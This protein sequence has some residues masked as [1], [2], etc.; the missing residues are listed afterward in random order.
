MNETILKNPLSSETI[1]VNDLEKYLKDANNILIYLDDDTIPY[2]MKR[3]YFI[4]LLSEDFVFECN[5]KNKIDVSIKYYDLSKLFLNVEGNHEIIVK[6]SD[7]IDIISDSGT[8]YFK[9]KSVVDKTTKKGIKKLTYTNIDLQKFVYNEGHDYT[10]TSDGIPP[11]WKA[12]AL[13]CGNGYTSINTYLVRLTDMPNVRRMKY[14]TGR[15]R[16]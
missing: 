9:L 7:I 15:T 4:N 16:F 5:S 14:R 3:T 13:Y 10:S 1:V 8:A 12:L 2:C 6:V 11:K